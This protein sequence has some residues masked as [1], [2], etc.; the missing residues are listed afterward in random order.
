MKVTEKTKISKLLGKVYSNIVVDSP[1]LY[2]IEPV[3]VC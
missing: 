3:L 1:L 2:G